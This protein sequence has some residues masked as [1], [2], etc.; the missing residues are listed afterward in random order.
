MSKRKLTRRQ[1]WQVEKVQQER[2]SRAQKKSRKAEK[3]IDRHDLGTEQTGRIIAHYGANLDV[4]D[5]NGA[6]HHC[7]TR[8][9]LP[10]LVC[11]DRVIWQ[12]TGEAMGVITALIP[13][14]SLLSR[15]GYNNQP[16]PVAA[17]ID[18]ILVVAAPSPS[19]D[20]DLINRYLVAAQLTDIAPVLVIN[21]TDLLSPAEHRQL[22]ERLAIY[23]TI[24]YSIIFTSTKQRD[25]LNSLLQRLKN[26]T[27]IFVGQSGVGKSSLIKVLIPQV[28]IRV[29]EISAAT[30]L[31]KHTTSVTVL[32]HLPNGG[33]IIDSPGVREFGLGPVSRDELSQGFVDFQP[34]LGQCK[35]NDCS[36]EQEPDCA[37]KHAVDTGAISKQRYD[38]FLRLARTLEQ[39]K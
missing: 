28:D 23:Q 5:D 27:S 31:G 9:N 15:H 2:L 29:G 34:W 11:G 21:K 16:K 22:T 26:R 38:S 12:A 33:A 3:L 8:A 7:L 36:H 4:E 30:G 18:Q 35:F 37:I 32:Y 25:G 17:N 14:T 39:R 20:E 10:Q 24:G 1:A 6:I 13:R 19:L